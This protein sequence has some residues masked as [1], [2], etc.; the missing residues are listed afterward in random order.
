MIPA[1]LH[2]K[3]LQAGYPTYASIAR[4]LKITRVT[5]HLIMT[6][7]RKSP[8]YIPR[9]NRLLGFDVRPHIPKQE[10]K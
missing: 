3:M 1:A 10:E 9:I 4:K 2:I 6:G 8:K 5:V 7:S